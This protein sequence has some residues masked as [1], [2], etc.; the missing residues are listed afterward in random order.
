MAFLHYEY[1]MK[2]Q[3]SEPVGKCCFTILSVPQE[4][5]R[6]RNISN[7]IHLSPEVRYSLSRD[8]FGNN[9][10]IGCEK[11]SHTEFVFQ[12]RGLI[13]TCPGCY[14]GWT[15]VRTLGMYKYEHGRCIPGKKIKAFAEEIRKD[16]EACGSVL[17]KCRCVMERLYRKMAYEPGSTL[18][19]TAAEE[20]FENGR[21]VCQDFAHI[22]ICL[23]RLYKIPARYVCGMI[24]G[25]GETHAWVEAD[26]NGRFAAFDPTYN[27]EIT[28][29]YIKLGVGRDAADC[30]INRGVMW[31]GGLQVQSI[32]AE[33]KRI[34]E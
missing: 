28:D 17:D 19:D 30:T 8:S 14:T 1:Q 31:G 13:E 22:Y 6:Q 7:E 34:Y 16:V 3:Y 23:L 21:G 5:T 32:R 9:K 26:V 12:I 10:I 25:E 15:D 33:V 4:D 11:E 2:I 18:V 24:L 27:R 20:A 29:E